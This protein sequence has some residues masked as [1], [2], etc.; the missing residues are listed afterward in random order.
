MPRVSWCATCRP[1]GV[2][3]EPCEQYR[4]Y[5][6]A[7]RRR[8]YEKTKQ[9]P[10]RLEV[11]R[12]RSRDGMQTLYDERLTQ[13]RSAQNTPLKQ[14]MTA[15]QEARVEEFVAKQRSIPRCENCPPTGRPCTPCRNAHRRATEGPDDAARLRRP[16]PRCENC[17]PFG[18]PCKPCLRKH[19]AAQMAER[20]KD[21]EYAAKRRAIQAA[22]EQAR[23]ERLA[24]QGTTRSRRRAEALTEA[25]A[26]ARHEHRLEV[27]RAWRAKKRAEAEAAGHVP[28]DV[29]AQ[30]VPRCENC[31]PKGSPCKPCYNR[32]KR[33]G[34]DIQ[35]RERPALAPRE[36]KPKAA[37]KPK[38]PRPAREAEVLTTVIPQA[39]VRERNYDLDTCTVCQSRGRWNGRQA[40]NRHADQ[41]APPPGWEESQKMVSYTAEARAAKGA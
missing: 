27:Q 35:P 9:D 11:H 32:H 33:G 24:A 13:G 14:K 40:C 41:V 31:P 18:E 5:I 29:T 20:M 8:S 17:P 3:C 2:R 25:E 10:V 38:A 37:P 6:N 23:N 22:A 4:L 12:Q 28:I 19:E 16:R 15:A 1:T 39:P 30:T 21:P 7:A 36:P 34:H 26:A